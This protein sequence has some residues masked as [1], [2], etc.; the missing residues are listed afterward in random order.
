MKKA[1]P[2]SKKSRDYSILLVDDEPTFLDVAEEML[3][4]IGYYDVTKAIN[5]ESALKHLVQGEFDLLI[6]DVVM[7]GRSGRELVEKSLELYPKMPIIVISG[8]QMDDYQ[9]VLDKGCKAFIQKP[10]Q[11]QNLDKVLKQV[12]KKKSSKPRTK[13]FYMDQYFKL[14]KKYEELVN[15]YCSTVSS[16]DFREKLENAYPY[17]IGGLVHDMNNTL[18]AILGNLLIID[19]KSR[20]PKRNRKNLKLVITAAE[21]QSAYIKYIGDLSHPFYSEEYRMAAGCKLWK[22]MKKIRSQAN[23]DKARFRLL[24]TGIKSIPILRKTRGSH[25]KH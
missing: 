25:L 8:Y 10:F 2:F 21:R 13:A 3:E 1:R 22:A 19:Y 11:L 12:L 24:T 4:T 17:I 18:A 20:L 23:I 15:E 6:T 16:I 5:T 9:E 14:R 7:P